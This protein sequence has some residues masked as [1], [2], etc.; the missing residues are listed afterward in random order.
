[1]VHG[2]RSGIIDIRSIKRNTFTIYDQPHC[3]KDSYTP[4]SFNFFLDRR[5]ET[6]PVRLIAAAAP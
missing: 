4:S 2:N 5:K 1:M 6:K 3:G